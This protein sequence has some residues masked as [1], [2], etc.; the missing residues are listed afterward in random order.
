MSLR[1]ARQFLI[2][3][4]TEERKVLTE[5]LTEECQFLSE[6]MTEESQCLTVIHSEET[7]SFRETRI[8]P[9]MKMS[10]QKLPVLLWFSPVVPPLPS[11]LK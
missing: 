1:E 11:F 2:K 5:I 7:Q 9:E 8:Y 3:I 4:I 10:F 6:N